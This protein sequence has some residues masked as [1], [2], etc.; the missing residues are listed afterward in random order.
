MSPTFLFWL[1]GFT[2]LFPLTTPLVPLIN[3]IGGILSIAT[4][5]GILVFGSI[6]PSSYVWVALLI[7]IVSSFPFVRQI[8]KSISI[9]LIGRHPSGLDVNLGDALIGSTVAVWYNHGWLEF[10]STHDGTWLIYLNWFLG[11]IRLWSFFG[12]FV[13]INSTRGRK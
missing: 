9:I 10:A 4:S 2:A 12:L 6:I 7:F 1:A 11:W 8:G 13:L 5:I 3:W